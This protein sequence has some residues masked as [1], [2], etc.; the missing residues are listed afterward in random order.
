[1]QDFDK[2]INKFC[3]VS[4]ALSDDFSLVIEGN[5][6]V[7]R[8]RL[9]DGL[10]FYD[11]DLKNGFDGVELYKHNKTSL[12]DARDFLTELKKWFLKQQTFLK[13]ASRDYLKKIDLSYW[14][15]KSYLIT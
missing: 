15:M 10:F 3:V 2:L 4:N 7:L 6:K 9:A 8:P 14:N 13:K 5:E 11:N 1:M 12:S